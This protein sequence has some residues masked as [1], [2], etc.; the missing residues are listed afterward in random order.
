MHA[1][2]AHAKAIGALN[3]LIPLRA[4]STEPTTALNAQAL[5]R[6]RAGRIVGWFGE[7]TDFVGISNCVKRSLSPRNAIQPRT[8]SLV[9][10]AG[11]MA[12]AAVYAMLQIGCKHVFVYNRTIANTVALARHF[13][14]QAQ[15]QV[16]GSTPATLQDNVRVI[17]NRTDPWPTESAPPTIV[18]SCV[19]HE[20]LDGNPGADFEMPEAWLQS[21]SGGVVVEMAYMTKE[22]PL[23]KQMKTF[24]ET[25]HRPWVLVDGIETLIEQAVGQFE[26][27][28]GRKAPKRCM[29]DAAH[30]SIR[31]KTSY[32]VDGEEFF[33]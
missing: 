3:T 1:L 25:T 6:N 32:L 28:T 12:R 33:A 14:N 26:S 20:L 31:Q 29:A 8:T 5:S 17:E 30:A 19:T 23:I 11:G 24:R 10:G 16:N 22:T 7:N 15:S 21:P 2:S 18:V 9:I 4:T 13:N 27:M